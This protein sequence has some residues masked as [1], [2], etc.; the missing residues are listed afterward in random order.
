MTSGRVVVF[1]SDRW[2]C[3]PVD[4][5]KKKGRKPTPTTQPRSR[6]A[7]ALPLFDPFPF[8]F[9]ASPCALLFFVP[10]FLICPHKQWQ[11]KKRA[12]G[13]LYKQGPFVEKKENSNR[14]KA[15]PNEKET[16][17]HPFFLSVSLSLS[18]SLDERK[19]KGGD[20]GA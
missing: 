9:F 16:T 12:H 17:A 4:D 3:L 19:E 7:R 1:V 11:R 2:M 13:R 8:F 15:Q 6:H 18:L 14:G 10:P 5:A 20:K